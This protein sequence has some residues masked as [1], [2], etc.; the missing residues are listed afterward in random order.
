MA[1]RHLD[2]GHIQVK[3]GVKMPVLYI[4]RKWKPAETR[5]STIER[6]C[7]GLVW[8]TKRLHPYLY[9]R[10]FILETDH[11]PLVFLNRSKVNNDRI[12]RW[13]LAMQLYRFQVRVIKG[14]ANSSADYLSRCGTN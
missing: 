9:G 4:S 1:M 11:Q 3:D 6:E 12:M 8:A 10:E 7:L 13:A 2:C 5:Y 14:S